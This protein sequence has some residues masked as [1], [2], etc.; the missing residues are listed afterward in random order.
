MVS[1]SVEEIGDMIQRALTY[2]VK[3]PKMS[4]QEEEDYLLSLSD[5]INKGKIFRGVYGDHGITIETRYMESIMLVRIRKNTL[6]FM[7]ISETSFFDSFMSVLEYISF[8]KKEENI[9][10]EFKIF[11]DE[12]DKD[13]LDDDMDTEDLPKKEPDD[14]DWI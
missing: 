9:M 7:P 2:G 13:L 5:F 10:K 1:N 8:R 4:K 11:I 3:L 12:V 6:E 14:F